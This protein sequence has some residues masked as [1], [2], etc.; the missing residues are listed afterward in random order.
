MKTRIVTAFAAAALVSTGYLLREVVGFREKPLETRTPEQPSVSVAVV[1]SAPFNPAT[2][3]VGHAEAVQAT[4][5]LPQIDGYI[6]RVCFAEGAKVEKG[7]LLFEI[8][9]EQYLAGL[10]SLTVV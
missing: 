1:K 4:D 6:L 10:S 8:D 2:E 7:D 3:H 9:P 5:I